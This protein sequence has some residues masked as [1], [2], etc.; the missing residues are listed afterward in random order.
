[1]SLSDGIL[2]KRVARAEIE[3]IVFVD[4]GRHDQKRRLLDL[5]RLRGI[6]D[7]LNQLVLKHDRSG[8]YRQIAADLEGGFVDPGNAPLLQIL[9]QVLHPGHQASRTCLDRRSNDFRI[10][11]GEIGRT[12][13]ID[14]LPRVEAKLQLRFFVDLCFIDELSQLLWSLER[15]IP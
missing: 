15:R 13:R 14:E 1:M 10:G 5:R 6:L 2:D 4:A 12:H 3:Q 7:E 9:D 8:R 11:H